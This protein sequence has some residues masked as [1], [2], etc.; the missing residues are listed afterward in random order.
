[1]DAV[2]KP[3]L[4]SSLLLRFSSPAASLRPPRLVLGLRPQASNAWSQGVRRL[5][6]GVVVVG[7]RAGQGVFDDAAIQHRPREAGGG[8]AS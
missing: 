7:D 1:M 2:I 3:I 4:A 8:G 6:L 5:H